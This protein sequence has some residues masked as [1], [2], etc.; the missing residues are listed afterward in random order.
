MAKEKKGPG[1]PK[2]AAKLAFKQAYAELEQAKAIGDKKL[3]AEKAA[4]LKGLV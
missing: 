3:I 1:S 2:S 4:V